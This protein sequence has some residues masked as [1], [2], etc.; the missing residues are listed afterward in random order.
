[1][2]TKKKLE[3]DR[4]IGNASYIEINC[5]LNYLPMSNKL[6]LEIINRM[7]ELECDELLQ[8]FLIDLRDSNKYRI[9]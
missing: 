8:Q 6:R 5:Y 9:V 1:M 4:F 7:E 2:H 3:Y